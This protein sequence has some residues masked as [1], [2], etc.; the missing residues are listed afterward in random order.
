MF[1][2]GRVSLVVGRDRGWEAECWGE[3][4]CVSV[5]VAGAVGTRM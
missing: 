2:L 1:S 3:G 4:G 5:C